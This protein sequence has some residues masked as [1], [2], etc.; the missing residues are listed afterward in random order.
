MLPQVKMHGECKQTQQ[1]N[2]LKV[3]FSAWLYIQYGLVAIHP[4]PFA[5]II[6][7]GIP[8]LT[9]ILIITLTVLTL[10]MVVVFIFFDVVF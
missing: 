1:S 5:R 4:I 7:P 6:F 10:T 2:V 3:Y 8:T 9:A